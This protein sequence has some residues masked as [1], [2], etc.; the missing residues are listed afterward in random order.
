MHPPPPK[1]NHFNSVFH[2]LR[3]SVFGRKKKTLRMAVVGMVGFN[4]TLIVFVALVVAGLRLISVIAMKNLLNLLMKEDHKEIKAEF[5]LICL[6][7]GL[8]GGSNVVALII[9]SYIHFVCKME[10]NR[11][12]T[13]LYGVVLEKAMRSTSLNHS[14]HTQGAILNYIQIDVTE[15]ENFLTDIYTIIASFLTLA[16]YYSYTYVL[17]DNAM[18]FIIGLSLG[19]TFI[20]GLLYG[21]FGSIRENLLD[22][23]DKRIEFIKNIVSRIQYIKMRAWENFYHYR[24]YYAR[25]IEMSYFKQIV[26]LMSIIVFLTWFAPTI[27]IIGMT[28]YQAYIATEIFSYDNI[29]AVLKM[30]YDSIDIIFEIPICINSLI[31]WNVSLNRIQS[32]LNQENIDLSWISKSN[33]SNQEHLL[34]LKNGNFYWDQ[35]ISTKST[36]DRNK[37]LKLVEDL[38]E[39]LVEESA[40]KLELREKTVFKL[41]NINLDLPKGGLVFIIGKS[42]SGKSSLIHSIL[43][44][45]KHSQTADEPISLIRESE[46]GVVTQKP[47]IL[48]RSIR[49]NITLGR[50][51]NEARLNKVVRL[52]ELEEDLKLMK[53]GIETVVGE[54]GQTLSGGQRTRIALA[55]CFYGTPKLMVLD[56]PLSALDMYVAKKIMNK[57]FLGEYR[58]S[59]KLISTNSIQYIKSAD[60]IYIIEEGEIVSK[61]KYDEVK[62]NPYYQEIKR[63]SEV[64]RH[65]IN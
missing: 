24:L 65:L 62:E 5:K 49:E 12:Q 10:S 26:A 48:G 30:S 20:I 4:F 52:S 59:T 41:T 51:F 28:I 61:G 58:E 32:F 19:L 29:S 9:E 11:I 6:Y 44:E 15:F 43:G 13:G 56:D 25:E 50:E 42:A 16:G 17:L 46:L 1:S 64:S 36:I 55:R 18:F 35:E 22:A 54:N 45:M 23:K 21:A 37:K 33:L 57:A 39:P 8:I 34:V 53:N 38:N 7:M 3:G 14:E 2:Q 47:W 60:L 63:I 31:T 40:S 27:G